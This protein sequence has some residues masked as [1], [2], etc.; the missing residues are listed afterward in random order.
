MIVSAALIV[1]PILVAEL[2][3]E[4]ASRLVPA[5]TLRSDMTAIVRQLRGLR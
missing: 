1:T 2:L 4:S 3:V 5:S